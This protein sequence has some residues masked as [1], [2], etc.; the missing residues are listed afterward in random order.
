MRVLPERSR[1]FRSWGGGGKGGGLQP[2]SPP[3]PPPAR[4]P[5]SSCLEQ[6]LESEA[7]DKKLKKENTERNNSER[8]YLNLT[9]VLNNLVL[10]FVLTFF[11]STMAKNE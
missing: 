11:K 8:K 1:Y 7:S 3:P 6:N 5:M 10:L 4:T 9:L 2:P